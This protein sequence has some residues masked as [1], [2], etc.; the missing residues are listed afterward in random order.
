MLYVCVCE[1]VCASHS[2][3]SDSMRPQGLYFTRLLC[4][5]LQ[6]RMLEWIAILPFPSPGIEPGYPEL[7]AYSLMFEPPGKPPNFLRWHSGKESACQC[8]RLKKH[9]FDPWVGKI[10]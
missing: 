5:N 3:V 4:R 7:Q 6:E 2:V 9:K 10:L 8:K 1:T